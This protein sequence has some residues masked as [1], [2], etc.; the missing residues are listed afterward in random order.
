M[1]FNDLVSAV[2]EAR[3]N[4]VDS[5]NWTRHWEPRW[6]ALIDLVGISYRSRVSPD[7]TVN[8]MVR[9]HRALTRT[10]DRYERVQVYRFSDS[11]YVTAST[12]IELL[13]FASD[14]QHVCLALNALAL[15]R[16]KPMFHFFVVPRVTIARGQV[17]EA[18]LNRRTP[19]PDLVGVD[20]QSLIA[21]EGIVRAYEIERRSAGSLIS[22]SSALP[23]VRGSV[24]GVEGAPRAILTRWVRD[25][26][27]AHDGV[28]DLPWLA[29]REDQPADADLWATSFR[30]AV[31]KVRVM[32]AMWQYSFGEYV[33]Q[34]A[35]IGSIKHA[36]AVDR[37]LSV[38]VQ[39]LRGFRSLQPWNEIELAEQI[40]GL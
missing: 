29:M 26:T 27:F 25:R 18:H 17:L 32:H 13:K 24:R 7:A 2:D 40:D 35:E 34:S 28:I 21:G 30:D 23:R 31:S 12:Q 5:R 8:Q 33:V 6:V 9:F 22:L 11:A 3:L 19:N 10:V 37:H 1:P 20:S 15:R 36:G 38:L 39:Q 4:A 14:F 16:V